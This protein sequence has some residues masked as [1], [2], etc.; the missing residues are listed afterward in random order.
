MILPDQFN[1]KNWK[2]GKI[3]YY[4]GMNDLYL[5]RIEDGKRQN[6]GLGTVR[7]RPGR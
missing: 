4:Q 6:N 1:D 5:I 2:F 7:Q 3:S